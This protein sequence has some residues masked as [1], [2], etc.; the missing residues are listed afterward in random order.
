MAK[1]DVLRKEL[2]QLRLAKEIISTNKDAKEEMAEIDRKIKD[3]HHQL[4]NNLTEEHEI[5]KE[6]RG[7]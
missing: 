2:F 6:G 5:K 7:K 3:V 1:K 4:T